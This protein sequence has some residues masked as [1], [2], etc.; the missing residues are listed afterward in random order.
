MLM[1]I[2]ADIDTNEFPAPQSQSVVVVLTA[3]GVVVDVLPDPGVVVVSTGGQRV[4]AV[5]G[6]VVV[7]DPL[8]VVRLVVVVVGGGS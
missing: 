6:V 5:H 7:V 4:G 1:T 3:P 8:V 2:N